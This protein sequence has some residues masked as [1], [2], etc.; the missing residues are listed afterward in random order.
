MGWITTFPID[1]MTLFTASG[2]G[3]GPFAITSEHQ[4]PNRLALAWDFW[5]QFYLALDERARVT[6]HAHWPWQW[7]DMAGQP[8]G[9]DA[10]TI[11]SATTD[12]IYTTH[13]YPDV[14]SWYKAGTNPPPNW[15]FN[16]W[17]I[18]LE[19]SGQPWRCWRL[20][21]VVDSAA[22]GLA[23]DV[24]QW[25]V[26][27]QGV[28]NPTVGGIPEP[29]HPGVIRVAGA[30]FTGE[31]NSF[32]ITYNGG[33]QAR[34]AK[35]SGE[36]ITLPNSDAVTADSAFHIG[37]AQSTNAIVGV[38]Y[39][40]QMRGATHWSDR[41]LETPYNPAG[42]TIHGGHVTP[43]YRGWPVSGGG[44]GATAMWNPS[45][46]GDWSQTM[47][48]GSGQNMYRAYSTSDGT[49]TYWFDIPADEYWDHV[50]GDAHDADC[51]GPGQI[52]IGQ[53]NWCRCFSPDLF[54]TIRGLQM[55]VQLL[56]PRFVQSGAMNAP[57][58]DPTFGSDFGMAYI[59]PVRWVDL[60]PI[61][62]HIGNN[63][64]VRPGAVIWWA[65]LLTRH[66]KDAHDNITLSYAPVQ[67]ALRANNAGQWVDPVPVSDPEPSTPAS[68]S[69]S[70][71]TVGDVVYSLGPTRRWPRQVRNMFYPATVFL[72]Q[73]IQRVKTDE[74]G[75]AV[76]DDYGPVLPPRDDIGDPDA[77]TP[78]FTEVGHW[79]TR[80]A[81]AKYMD[82]D[83]F[84]EGEVARDLGD[85]WD[86]TDWWEWVGDVRGSWASAVDDLRNPPPLRDYVAAAIRRVTPGDKEKI[87]PGGN[88]PMNPRALDVSGVAVA[89]GD[90]WLSCPDTQGWPGTMITH[91]GTATGGS[92]T[93]LSDATKAAVDENARTSQPGR[94]WDS[95]TGRFAGFTIEIETSAG[96]WESRFITS[97]SDYRAASN[98]CTCSFAALSTPVTAG[99]AYRIREP[100]HKLNPWRDH[101]L[102][103]TRN[104]AVI[105]SVML[106]GNND[107][108]LFWP[109]GGLVAQAG[110]TFTIEVIVP[111]QCWLRRGG[112]WIK[113]PT[114]END[115]R[116]QISVPGQRAGL[117]YTAGHNP[118][119][120]DQTAIAPTAVSGYGL[121][122]EYDYLGEWLF[123]ELHDGIVQLHYPFVSV[124]AG[125]S[126]MVNGAEAGY[127]SSRFT[128]PR[129]PQYAGW[130]Y[131][132]HDQNPTLDLA[133]GR[134]TGTY[135]VD[136]GSGLSIG[137]QTNNSNEI[138]L[139]RSFV[140][141]DAANNNYGYPDGPMYY[142]NY[143]IN[144]CALTAS[145]SLWP[146]MSIGG[147][148]V[149]YAVDK[150]TD[151]RWDWFLAPNMGIDMVS[152]I[153]RRYFDV[154]L[155]STS[156]PGTFASGGAVE[157]GTFVWA[158]LPSGAP[159]HAPSGAVVGHTEGTITWRV[160]GTSATV[161]Y[162][163]AL[164]YS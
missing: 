27:Y 17:E 4:L 55:G 163:V 159:P 23:V 148:N 12:H 113:P 13:D 70:W 7:C 160:V 20:P 88:W 128:D 146:M 48:W 8:R 104:G 53:S 124:G 61:D 141:W 68:G 58:D 52:N 130:P 149:Y 139:M 14:V 100:M 164:E 136:S 96:V 152:T 36:F 93:T 115:T 56:A 87:Y 98:K 144:K 78:P 99:M 123:N 26:E 54:K 74:Y 143:L 154:A 38:G 66:T 29:N 59:P 85:T 86:G 121:Y 117:I 158:P 31:W 34:I 45:P 116:L 133:K 5:K 138:P 81:D 32:W 28:A 127:G 1:S 118:W 18:V 69:V 40:I 80:A 25:L 162:S 63:V 3:V 21:C 106:S 65:Y 75:Q 84:V 16:N 137:K 46:S 103:I 11:Q 134:A 114:T 94:F 145:A 142:A 2:S 73:Y 83:T 62:S 119:P 47:L 72:P 122:A 135:I 155:S 77:V 42:G 153:E 95:A 120:D 97:F 22:N 39:T 131:W 108:H 90:G 49:N 102:T 110:D 60:F 109:A 50:F 91:T 43:W 92:T 41:W 30:A 51:W 105:G 19:V 112:Q 79:M 57:H 101:K 126:G 67:G 35:C 24:N 157:I 37:R 147:I 156:T 111:G 82:G 89:G 44:G 132:Y 64:N 107:T 129:S 150:E 71:N 140:A 9:L 6:G 15:P 151:K 161:V 33:A 10:G 125:F 76:V